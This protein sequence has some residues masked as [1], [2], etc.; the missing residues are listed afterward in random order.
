MTLNCCLYPLCLNAD[1]PLCGRSAAVL[2]EPLNQCNI[3]TVILVD[4]SRVP[5]AEAVCADALI[6]QVIANDGNQGLRRGQ[7]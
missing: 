5:L 7:R 3:I 2:Q 1:V 4:F 6:V